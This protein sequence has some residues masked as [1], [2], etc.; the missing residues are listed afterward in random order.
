MASRKSVPSQFF[1]DIDFLERYESRK[2]ESARWSANRLTYHASN[3]AGQRGVSHKEIERVLS[4]AAGCGDARQEVTT[5][6]GTKAVV[7]AGKVVT[8]LPQNDRIAKRTFVQDVP[9]LTVDK[10]QNSVVVPRAF[11]NEHTCEELNSIAS[12]FTIP[13]LPECRIL[14]PEMTDSQPVLVKLVVVGAQLESVARKISEVLG[15]WE[16]VEG[17]RPQLVIGPDGKTIKHLVS[18]VPRCRIIVPSK[19]AMYKGKRDTRIVLRGVAGQVKVMRLL[20]DCLHEHRNLRVCPSC[21]DRFSLSKQARKHVAEKHGANDITKKMMEEAGLDES[22]RILSE[23]AL[24]QSPPR[25][26]HLLR[27]Q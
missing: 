4:L 22:M 5:P 13:G 26:A 9:E 18:L 10:A 8:F 12:K 14:V 24:E 3:R 19:D 6:N 20:L 23:L 7:C 2:A 25:V 11:L 1:D 16:M 15:P 27:L 17:M 21:G